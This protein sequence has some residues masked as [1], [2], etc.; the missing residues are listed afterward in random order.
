MT[1]EKKL[2]IIITQPIASPLLDIPIIN[3]NVQRC[4]QIECVCGFFKRTLKVKPN[5]ERSTRLLV[6]LP[7]PAVDLVKVKVITPL[8]SIGKSNV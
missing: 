4:H 7:V 5:T 3:I 2:I 1:R 8:S 6:T